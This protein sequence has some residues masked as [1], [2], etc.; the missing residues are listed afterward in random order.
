MSKIKALKAQNLGGQTPKSI[1]NF[2]VNT[3]PEGLI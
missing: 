1:A 2:E 3:T